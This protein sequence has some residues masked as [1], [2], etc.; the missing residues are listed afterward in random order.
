M[1]LAASSWAWSYP[2]SHIP[3][4]VLLA[5]AD[6]HNGITGLCCPSVAHLV[7]MTGLDRAS[8]F[9]GLATLKKEGLVEVQQSKGHPS[10][11]LLTGN[12]PVAN[13]DGW[14]AN[15]D[16]TRRYQRR[17]TGTQPESNNPPNPL[18]R[19][20]GAEATSSISSNSATP[21]G[22]A[23]DFHPKSDIRLPA[24]PPEVR[25][26]VPRIPLTKRN[27]H[28]TGLARHSS[29]VSTQSGSREHRNG[30]RASR[31][32]PEPRNIPKSDPPEMY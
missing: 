12:L 29:H 16:G 3:K 17:V 27:G 20:N 26:L 7:Q 28:S 5:L 1:S 21:N 25:D 9:R 18:K 23:D 4:L 24:G 19:G 31:A 32:V 22:V 13:R 6:C 15:R 11:Y 30:R 2:L 10:K 14:V 8:V